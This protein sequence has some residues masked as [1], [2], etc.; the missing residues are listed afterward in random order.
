[1]KQIWILAQNTIKALVRKKDFYVFFMMLSVLL[2]FLFTEKFFGIGDI[3]RHTKDIG[4]FCLWLFSFIIGATFS[5]RQLPEEISSKAVFS[6]LAKPV[7][8]MHF[9]V[10]RFFGAL[11]AASCAYTVFYIA[12]IGVTLM[13]GEG[14]AGALLIQAYLLGI[15]FLSMVC[16]ISMFLTLYLTLSAAITASFIIYF[17][18]VWFIDILRAMVIYAEGWRLFFSNLIFYLIPHYEFYDLR[19]RLAHSWEALPLWVACSIILYTILYVS[20]IL[21][22]GHLKLKKKVF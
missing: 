22:L 9:L 6:L 7:S 12:Y 4:Y 14:I 13:K 3:S 5:A 11:L 21:C 17:A 10:G 15:C 16:A 18:I 20:A 8:R 19:V 2:L 1:M